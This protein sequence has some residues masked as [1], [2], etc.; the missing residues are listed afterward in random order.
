[1]ET[2]G[3]GSIRNPSQRTLGR[4]EAPAEFGHLGWDQATS[5]TYRALLWLGADTDVCR[6]LQPTLV[7][8]MWRRIQ[9]LTVVLGSGLLLA[10]GGGAS[11]RP[12]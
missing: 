5:A 4:S 7:I 3:A 1:M 11:Y 6:V 12:F 2:S 8:L 9:K 10:L